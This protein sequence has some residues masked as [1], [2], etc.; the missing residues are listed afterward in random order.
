MKQEKLFNDNDLELNTDYVSPGDKRKWT[1]A[2]IRWC[3]SEYNPNCSPFNC[4]CMNI[5][6]LCKM[7]KGRGFA[8]CVETIKEWYKENKDEIP[9]KNYNFEELFQKTEEIKH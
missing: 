9:Y 2:F 3:E 4:G 6:K 8:D 1:N 5:C 7:K